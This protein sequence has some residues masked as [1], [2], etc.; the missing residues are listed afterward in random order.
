[1]QPGDLY[2]LLA[3]VMLL[4]ASVCAIQIR[5]QRPDA[6]AKRRVDFCLGM[7]CLIAWLGVVA[8]DLLP[9]RL[10]WSDSLPL[11][12]C[13]FAGIFAAL[14][15][16]TNW[17]WARSLSLFVGLGLSALAFVWPVVTKGP[18]RPDYWVYFGGH[19]AIVLAAIY[20]LTAR[21]FRTTAADLRVAVTSIP[22][23]AIIVVPLDAGLGV[24][25]GYLGDVS[26]SARPIFEAFGPWPYRIPSLLL[27]AASIM[28]GLHLLTKVRR[29]QPWQTAPEPVTATTG[30]PSRARSPL[31]YVVTAPGPAWRGHGAGADRLS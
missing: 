15:L 9:S 12:I 19:G 21:G 31:P 30:R 6:A 22:I 23:Y 24:N 26:T 14:S 17:R 5:A 10:S 20:D 4:A 25:Y 1:M 27:V 3:I 2:H 18:W 13:D 28:C 11:H 8:S 16:L 7:L 29:A